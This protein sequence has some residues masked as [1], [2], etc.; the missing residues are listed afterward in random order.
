MH[1]YNKMIAFHGEPLHVLDRAWIVLAYPNPQSP[2]GYSFIGVL[3][4]RIS[5]QAML[6]IVEQIY[7]LYAQEPSQENPIDT[8]KPHIGFFYLN[9]GSPC[10]DRITCWGKSSMH[11][12]AIQVYDVTFATDEH[13]VKYVKWRE[14]HYNVNSRGIRETEFWEELGLAIEGIHELIRFDDDQSTTLT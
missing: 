9:D 4:H 7:S 11:L 6:R 2:P 13:E 3:D 1:K 10:E 8:D 12:E 5:G 14:E